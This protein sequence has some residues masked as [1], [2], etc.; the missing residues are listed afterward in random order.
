[1]SDNLKWA[2]CPICFDTVNE[3]QLKSVKWYDGPQDDREPDVS[4]GSSSVKQLFDHEAAP[5][6]G[7]TM[8]MR[9]MQRPQITTLALPRSHTWPSDL[10]PP[11]QAPFYFLPD[12]Y[13]YAKFMLA[14]P[15]YLIA[16][17]SND[18]DALAMERRMMTSMQDELSILFIDAAEQKLRHQIAKVAALDSPQLKEAIDRAQ[19]DYEDIEHRHNVEHERKLQG[20]SKGAA[21]PEAPEAFLAIRSSSGYSPSSRTLSSISTTP[22]PAPS[23]APIPTLPTN[24]SSNNRNHRQRRNVNPPPPST[25]TYYYYQAASGLPIFLHPLDIKILFSHFNSYASFPDTIS[26]RVESAAEGTIN[27]DLRKRCKYLAH[28]PE[29]ADV[30]FIEADLEEVVGQEGLKNFEGAIKLRKSR[31][32]EKGKKD[33]RARVRAEEREREKVITPWSESVVSTPL[34]PVVDP[35]EVEGIVGH[36]P[37]APQISGAWGSRSFASAA[38]SASRA[39]VGRSN[40]NNHTAS[41]EIADEWELDAAWHELEQRSTTGSGNKKKR[42]NKLVVL[43]GGAGGRR[44]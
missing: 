15:D 41:Q 13:N 38:H 19:R 34:D 37:P 24:A 42:S 7:S 21:L 36:E 32:K 39:D 6:A 29:G 5:R 4:G 28:T 35:V 25:Q 20:E 33:D 14:T 44:R 9:L 8:R 1:M 26:V 2:R 22:K 18:L 11:H 30:V 12:V 27:D 17:L 31:R 10:I 3:K 43:G 40:S 16:D 23:P